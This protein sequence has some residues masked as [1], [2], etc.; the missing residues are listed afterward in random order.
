LRARAG[1]TRE[2]L[3]RALGIDAGIDVTTFNALADSIS[4]PTGAG[5]AVLKVRAA[6]LGRS[7]AAVLSIAGVCLLKPGCMLNKSWASWLREAPV[8]TLD[9]R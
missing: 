9:R 5:T 8:R 1:L 7:A 4:Y 3:Q 6:P 2:A